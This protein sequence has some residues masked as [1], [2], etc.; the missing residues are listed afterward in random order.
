MKGKGVKGVMGLIFLRLNH[1]SLSFDGQQ[2]IRYTI[3]VH[4]QTTEMDLEFAKISGF[5]IWMI[6]SLNVL[7]L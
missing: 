3:K 5:I 2:T 4:H 7:P 1:V 6:F